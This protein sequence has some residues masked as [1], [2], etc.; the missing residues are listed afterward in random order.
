MNLPEIVLASSSPRRREI[1]SWTGMAFS[2]QAPEVDETPLADEQP[3]DYVVRLADAKAKIAAHFAPFNGL[4]LAADTA[5]A[6]GSG[7][8]GK[9]ESTDD[10]RR[11]LMRLRGRTHHVYTAIAV[12]IPS[13]GMIQQTTC[14][15]Q[16]RMRTYSDKEMETYLA[17]GDPM[18]KAGAYAIQ[19][20]EFQPV[21]K[22]NGCFANVMGLP[23]CHFEHT[24]R[25]LGYGER[26][27]VPYQ[28]Q[29]ALSYSCPIFRHV[30]NGENVG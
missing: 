24:L 27:E 5:V 4:V 7:I 10:A 18:D 21:V 14:T 1:L 30:L 15:T 9:P 20:P 6:D 2:T 13:K 28:C 22:F 12:A 11:M 25:Q 16:V 26:K 17:T 8:L 23:L 19:H 29:D 3:F